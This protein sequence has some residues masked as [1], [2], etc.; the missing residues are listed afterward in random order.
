M[1]APAVPLAR[2]KDV[3]LPR[4]DVRSAWLT[5]YGLDAQFFEAEILPG[6][7]PTR[8]PHDAQTGSLSAYLHEA[9]QTTATVPVDVLYDH[10]TGESNKLFLNYR[11]VDLGNAAF[12]P[13]VLVAEYDDV[14]RVVVTSAN[15]TRAGWTSQF[16]VFTMQDLRRNVPSSWRR[17]LASML[18]AVTPAGA[19]T[20]AA[21]ARAL[22]FLA[23]VPGCEEDTF[24]HS[25]D[26]ALLD[27]ALPAGP[28]SSIDIV[29]PFFEGEDGPGLFDELQTRYPSARLRIFLAASSTERGYVVHGPEAKLIAA[30]EAGAE[31]RLV[32]GA[33][34]GDDDRAPDRR[35]LHGKLLGFVSG[36]TAHVVVGSA[37]ATRA[38]L[39]RCVTNNGN[40][41]VVV[42]LQ[43]QA[44][45]YRR[46]LPPSR[47][48]DDDVLFEAGDV[49]GEE[50][51]E[52]GA[53][54]HVVSA[55]YHA[56]SDELRVVL[57][58]GSPPLEV[59]YSGRSLG[60]TSGE[61]WQGRLAPLTIDACITVDE[62]TGPCPVPIL[63]LDPESLMP[64]GTPS[65]V[66]LESLADLLAGRR[67]LVHPEGDRLGGT[68]E[69]PGRAG[70]L[71]GTRGAIPWRRIL[72]GLRGLHDDLVSQLDVPEAV[73]WTLENPWRL[74]GLLDQFRSAYA[75]GRFLE[76]DLA[77]AL[78]ETHALL[79]EVLARTEPGV[80]HDLITKKCEQVRS[81][82]DTSLQ[83]GNAMV[84]KQLK[85]LR[86]G[87]QPA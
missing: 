65:D 54:R 17:G 61:V 58:P 29:S 46:L 79:T 5:T 48:A 9:D 39:L 36:S 78:H 44:A 60:T 63:L 27:S 26:G 3:L 38:G 45:A 23:T 86:D 43:V 50:E 28:I 57:R 35:S 40:A 83:G 52:L 72:A 47:S 42:T 70:G 30:R 22:A 51:A 49:S 14:L 12:H 24:H 19:G 68:G 7:V 53:D 4:Q 82:L 73:R 6:L 64:R 69:G 85:V 21:A 74:G 8:L 33:W 13:K 20:G 1:T 15:L 56:R 10:L 77:F 55:T 18:E 75:Q 87:S 59:G 37:N 66:D 62:G 2:L 71:P 31:L 81:E 41:E 80:S 67:Q 32:D 34:P 84:R 16:E 11:R 25:Y 76:G